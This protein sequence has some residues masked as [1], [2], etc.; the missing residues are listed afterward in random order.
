MPG[1]DWGSATAS[2]VKGCR[3]VAGLPYEGACFALCKK[4]NKG[5]IL[6]CTDNGKR[7]LQPPGP[8]LANHDTHA[9]PDVS[10]AR[11]LAV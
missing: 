3:S 1:A 2:N 11:Y 4:I 10:S 7:R 9:R 6:R 8:A 5:E